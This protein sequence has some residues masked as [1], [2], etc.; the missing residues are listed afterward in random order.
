[1]LQEKAGGK[2][3]QVVKEHLAQVFFQQ[4]CCPDNVQAPQ[5]AKDRYSQCNDD[6]EEDQAAKIRP[7]YR[8]G[9]QCIGK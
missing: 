5:I 9:Q 2:T 7:I 3:L 4:A 8:G 1:M 6:N